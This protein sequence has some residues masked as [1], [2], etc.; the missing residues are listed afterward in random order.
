[1]QHPG[2]HPFHHETSFIYLTGL[3]YFIII[4]L[5]LLFFRPFDYSPLSCDLRIFS[6][7]DQKL[8]TKIR[9]FNNFTFLHFPVIPTERFITRSQFYETSVTHTSAPNTFQQHSLCFY[10]R[11]NND[12]ILN[13]IFFPNAM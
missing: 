2:E 12:L 5:S 4:Y 9:C 8:L 3:S 6:G 10:A 11:K 13:Y 1:M 7:Y